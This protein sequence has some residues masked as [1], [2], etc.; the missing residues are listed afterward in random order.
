MLSVH[1]KN[2]TDHIVCKYV[3][4]VCIHWRTQKRVRGF[5]PLIESSE[6]FELCVCKIYC[7]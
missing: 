6:F 5:K 3:S 2:G 1:G 4:V 7:H